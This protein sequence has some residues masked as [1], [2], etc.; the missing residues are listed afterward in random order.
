MAMLESLCQLIFNV[1]EAFTVA[2]FVREKECL[3]CLS[4]VTF[5]GSFDRS[6]VVPVEGTL[7]GWVLKHNEPL[8]IPNFDKNEG[9]L[10][11]Y[12]ETEDIKSFMGYPVDG[13]GVLVVD[14]KKKWVFTDKE[15][16]ILG[17]FVSVIHREMEREKR[18]QD[19]EERIDEL[20][21]ERRI[22]S[23]FNGLNIAKTP[24]EEVFREAAA[25][26]GADFCFVCMEKNGSIRIHDTFG[27]ESSEYRG[28]ECTSSSSIAS[29]VMDKGSELLL[30][31]SSG[32][33]KERPLFFAGE[34][35]RPR[36]LFGF[37]LI[38][39]DM[40]LGVLGFVSTGD[41]HLK[42]DSILL[43]RQISTLFSMHY[44]ALWM[45]QNLERVKDYEPTTGCIHFPTFLRIADNTVKKREPFALLSVKIAHLDLYNQ[46]MGYEFT[47]NLLRKVFHV[48][49]YS[50]GRNAV[51]AR[52]GGG[53]F[54]I[55]IRDNRIVELH[56]V[57][58]ILHYTITKNISEEKVI[59]NA[60]LVE[61]GMSNF[62]EDGDNLWELIAKAKDH[63]IR[64]SKR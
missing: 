16:K 43:L 22:I 51:I 42:E 11:Y 7:P 59:E 4:S 53:H 17:A 23:L 6:R 49:R 9:T 46:R 18:F 55:I 30:P 58:K 63:G 34:T 40:I 60:T 25:L 48:I 1:Y 64:K 38:L 8:V 5:A 29:A 15:K 37:P 47:D 33:L 62:P 35:V 54:Y 10:G 41:T 36:Q 44:G 39:E 52:E 19:I 56:N 61:S 57:L 45:R 3:K 50:V 21:R 20:N 2:L 27:P 14:T 13:E 12:G 28:R 32:Y 24:V 31:H 26:S